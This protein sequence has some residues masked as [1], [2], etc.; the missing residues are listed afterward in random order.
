LEYGTVC[1]VNLWWFGIL[2]LTLLKLP[3]HNAWL[4]VAESPLL[5]L[6]QVSLSALLL[7]NIAVQLYAWI[8]VVRKSKERGI[9]MIIPHIILALL[10]SGN[11]SKYSYSQIPFLTLEI[12]SQ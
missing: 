11:L 1:L 5:Y 8:A 10:L 7:A 12:I 9:K 4:D 2:M 3:E 6:V